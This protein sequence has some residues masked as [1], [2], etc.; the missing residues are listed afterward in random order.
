MHWAGRWRV[1][2]PWG[3]GPR[4]GG[5]W[6][7][8]SFGTERSP[9]RLRNEGRAIRG[10]IAMTNIPVKTPLPI[11]ARMV[12]TA[13]QYAQIAATYEHAAADWTLPLQP[14]AAFA[15]KACWFRMR[16]QITAAKQAMALPPNVFPLMERQPYRPLV[17]TGIWKATPSP[18]PRRRGALNV[19]NHAA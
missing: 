15:K 12:L 10:R 9:K 18:T 11:K 5:P 17:G 13:P 7:H 16:A 19:L 3:V 14:R 2:G 8:P 1:K 6:T 4:V